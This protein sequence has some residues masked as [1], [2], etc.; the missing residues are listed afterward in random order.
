MDQEAMIASDIIDNLGEAFKIIKA[1]PFL[2]EGRGTQFI[3][4]I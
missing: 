1:K 3:A 2:H 4:P